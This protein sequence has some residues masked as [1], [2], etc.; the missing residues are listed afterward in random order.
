MFLFPGPG[1]LDNAVNTCKSR[2]P[3]EHLSRFCRISDQPGRVA[4]APRFHSGVDRFTADLSRGL[5]HLEDRE[6]SAIPEIDLVR[7]TSRLEILERQNMSIGE[8]RH[9]NVVAD[10]SSLRRIIVV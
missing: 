10:A 2:F 6:P 3:A 7:L 4:C 9:V 8:V 5:D 1:R